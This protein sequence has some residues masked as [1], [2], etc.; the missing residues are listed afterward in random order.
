MFVNK[1]LE[2]ILKNV[3][4]YNNLLTKTLP[5]SIYTNLNVYVTH[6]VK[7]QYF[8]KISNTSWKA[9]NFKY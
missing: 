6:K 9:E 7:I 1:L 5:V 4:S 3:T 2:K 8:N